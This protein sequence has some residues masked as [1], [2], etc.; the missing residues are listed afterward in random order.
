[1]TT[2]RKDY[3]GRVLRRGESQRKDDKRYIYQYTDPNGNRRVVYANDLAELKKKCGKNKGIRHALSLEQQRA[4]LSY[5][6]NSPIYCHW[7]PIFTVLFGTGCR[8]GEL[9][10]LRWEDLD[11]EKKLISI[12]HAAIYMFMEN[13][14]S[15]FHIST[16]KTKAGTR[17]IPM[18]GAVEQA[19]KDEYEAQKETGFNTDMVDGMSGFVFCNREGKLKDDIKFMERHQSII[20]WWTNMDSLFRGDEY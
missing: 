20:L 8:I 19:F 14:K 12:N 15:E 10:G 11:Y 7:L 17:I 4:F 6:K 1:M 5:V 16:P 13:G 9:V 2:G 18:M 3:K